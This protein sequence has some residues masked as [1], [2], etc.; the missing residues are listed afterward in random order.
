[1]MFC[2]CSAC[3][4]ESGCPVKNKYERLPPEYF[5]KAKGKCLKL[6]KARQQF[7]KELNEYDNAV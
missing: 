3:E 7:L 2:D 6:E 4:L 1:M 5:P